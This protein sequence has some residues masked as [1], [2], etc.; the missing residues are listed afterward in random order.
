MNGLKPVTLW[1]VWVCVTSTYCH[2]KYTNMSEMITSLVQASKVA[3][4]EKDF[5]KKLSHAASMER[6]HL[7]KAAKYGSVVKAGVMAIANQDIEQA[8]LV[9]SMFTITAAGRVKVSDMKSFNKVKPTQLCDFL[10]LKDKKKEVQGRNEAMKRQRSIVDLTEE[11]EPV[12]R[13]RHA[14]LEDG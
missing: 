11:E 4:G 6:K 5:F 7:D 14:M 1:G 2:I 3:K 8:R 9:D 13:K 12:T 10:A